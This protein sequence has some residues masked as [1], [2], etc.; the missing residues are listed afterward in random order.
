MLSPGFRKRLVALG[1][2][3]LDALLSQALPPVF[4]EFEAD[5]P[6]TAIGFA[7]SQKDLKTFSQKGPCGGDGCF[8][9]EADIDSKSTKTPWIRN[10]GRD[11]DG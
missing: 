2:E 7:T 4:L 1:E 11:A 10:N 3:G 5:R 6:I 9:L 8:S